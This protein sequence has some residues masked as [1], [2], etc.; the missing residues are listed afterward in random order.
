VLNG[1]V[2]LLLMM[3]HLFLFTECM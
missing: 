1:F 2:I 3:D